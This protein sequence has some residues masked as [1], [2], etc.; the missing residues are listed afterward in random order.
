MIGKTIEEDLKEDKET[1]I[2]DRCFLKYLNLNRKIEIM[3]LYFS[4]LDELFSSDSIMDE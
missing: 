1:Q 2:H 4:I 3:G